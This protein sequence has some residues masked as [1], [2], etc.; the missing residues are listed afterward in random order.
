MANELRYRPPFSH[1]QR[2]TLEVQCALSLQLLRPQGVAAVVRHT[3]I[4][5][6]PSAGSARATSAT[7][8]RSLIMSKAGIPSC[9]LAETLLWAL[10]LAMGVAQR[11]ACRVQAGS[12]FVGVLIARHL[13]GRCSILLVLFTFLL[14]SSR[15]PPLLLASR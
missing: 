3:R 11:A 13:A 4:P 15:S 9:S 5:L 7:R 1:S 10:D 8:P 2:W 12:A 14:S 6:R